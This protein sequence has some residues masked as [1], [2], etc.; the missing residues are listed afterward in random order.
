MPR[1]YQRLFSLS[2]EHTKGITAVAFSPRGTF[3][4]TGGL[5]GKVGWWR[6]EDGKLLYVWCG[7]SAVLSLAWVPGEESSILCGFQDGNLAVVRV[8]MV[9][10]RSTMHVRQMLTHFRTPSISMASGLIS[11]LW[12]V[13]QSTAA[14]WPQVLIRSS[15]F[16]TGTWTVSIPAH[17]LHRSS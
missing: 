17:R 2:N 11:I 13:S 15:K 14:E 5:D 1:K 6:V 12:S 4:A 9:C 8:T 16:G 7:N 3:V 10:S